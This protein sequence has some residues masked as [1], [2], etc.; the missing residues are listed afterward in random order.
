MSLP[1]EETHQANGMCTANNN[2]KNNKPINEVHLH[3][4]LGFGNHST[5]QIQTLTSENQSY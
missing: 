3:Q 2:E 1:A 4:I 5:M